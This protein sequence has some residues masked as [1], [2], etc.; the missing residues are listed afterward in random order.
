MEKTWGRREFHCCI[1]A[2]CVE[3]T[4]S[5]K[6]VHHGRSIEAALATSR[7]ANGRT[8]ILCVRAAS[9]WSAVFFTSQCFSFALIGLG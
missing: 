5:C 4:V 6:P 1:T 8:G 2:M 9:F 3:R 7:H